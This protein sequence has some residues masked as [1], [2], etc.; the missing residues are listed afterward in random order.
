MIPETSTPRPRVVAIGGGHGA[1]QTLRAARRYAGDITAVISVADDGGSSGRLRDELG[2]PAPG[3]IRRCIGALLPDESPLGAA[4]EHRFSSG[5]LS[6]H[7]FGNLLIAA[8]AGAKGDFTA[9]AS[10]AA[11]LLGAVG[12]VFPATVTPVVLK[13]TGAAGEVS[14]QARITAQGGISHVELVPPDPEP[15]RGAVDALLAADQIVIGPGSLYTSLLAATAVP[16]LREAILRSR[17][18]RVYVANLRE[19]PPETAGFLVADH[20]RALIDHGLV[21]DVVLADE[22]GLRIGDVPSSVA[23]E[24]A[25]LATEGLGAHDPDLLAKAL[26][27][28]VLA[29]M[30]SA[31]E[32]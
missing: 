11:R 17:A 3:D 22:R 12:R 23:I 8:L 13:G 5:E 6:G 7:A 20:V 32:K 26:S 24:R 2:I 4:L 29:R 9:G 18:Q 25:E 27:A 16:A 19:Q 28:L 15:P 30:G 1:A 31:G 10:E 21:V 14:G